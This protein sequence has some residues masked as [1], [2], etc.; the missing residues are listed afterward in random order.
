MM[1]AAGT[2]RRE[3]VGNAKPG[4]RPHG[5]HGIPE[6]TPHAKMLHGTHYG[7]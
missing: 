6:E 7:C 1:L 4:Y 5:L 3:Q 2:E